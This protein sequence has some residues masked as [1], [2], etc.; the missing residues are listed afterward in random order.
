[1]L[2]INALGG[3]A[4]LRDGTPVTGDAVQPRRLAL[5]AA[6]ARAGSRGMTRERVLALLWPDTDEDRARRTLSQ[7]IYSLRRGMGDDAL[8]GTTEL[9]LDPSLVTSDVA[10]FTEAIRERDFER[11]VSLYTGPFLDGV[12]VVGVPDFDRWADAER[13]ALAHDYATALERVAKAAAAKADWARA[14]GWWRKRA[15]LDPVDP[16]LALEVMRSLAASGDRSGALQQARVFTALR[17]QDDLPPDA[18]VE[19]LAR[20]LREAPAEPV[21]PAGVIPSGASAQHEPRRGI[22]GLS[23]EESLSRDP[24]SLAFPRPGSGDS[25]TARPDSHS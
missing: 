4:L 22:A 5:L 6:L 11:A 14:A 20:Q 19:E 15:A 17:A 18:Q 23:A 25:S 8:A 13:S 3:I 9:R 10:E 7:A 1:M 24:S 12:R 2:R 21:A 16:R